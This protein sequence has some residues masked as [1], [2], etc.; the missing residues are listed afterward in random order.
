MWA[1]G[2]DDR[3]ATLTFEPPAGSAWQV[4]TQLHPGAT[5]LEFTAPNLQYLMDSPVEFGPVAIRQFTVGPRTFRFAVHHTGTDAELD[6][7]VKDVEKIV[8]QEGAIFGE[9]PGLRAGPLHVPRRL[10]AVRERRRH[11]APQQ[12]GHDR[13]RRRSRSG[14]A[15]ACSTRWRTS[16][17]TAGTSSAS[18]RAR[19]SRSISSA[20]TCR[21]SCGSPKASRSTT[22]RSS[23][24]RAGLVDLSRDRAQRSPSL[25]EAVDA[26]ARAARCDR[27]KR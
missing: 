11:G 1:R 10:P 13:R 8:R 19:S 23:L 15:R 25:V 5:P 3:P 27:P 12:H 4:A 6:A 14:R 7:F 2:L 18:G 24:Q 21:A 17:S 16:S 26:R 22:G 9:Y 20:R